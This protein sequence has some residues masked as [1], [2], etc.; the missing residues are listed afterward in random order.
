MN[1]LK[2]CTILLFATLTSIISLANADYNT[3]ISYS[4]ALIRNKRGFGG[5]KS[6]YDPHGMSGMISTLAAA[7]YLVLQ[8]IKEDKFCVINFKVLKIE[9]AL[10]IDPKDHSKFLYPDDKGNIYFK[11]G[12]PVFLSCAQEES[13]CFNRLPKQSSQTFICRLFDFNELACNSHPKHSLKLVKDDSHYQKFEELKYWKDRRLAEY[14]KYTVSK[15]LLAGQ[16]TNVKIPLPPG[17]CCRVIPSILQALNEDAQI[18]SFKELLPYQSYESEKGYFRI[19]GRDRLASR[20]ANVY[21]AAAL[22]TY[23]FTNIIP[24]FKCII[25]NNWPKIDEHINEMAITL[26]KGSDGV[27][28]RS[29]RKGVVYVTVNDIFMDDRSAASYHICKNPIFKM[30]GVKMPRGWQPKKYYAGYSYMCT[31][32]PRGDDEQTEIESFTPAEEKTTPA[33]KRTTTVSHTT[34]EEITTTTEKYWVI[35]DE[36]R[37]RNDYNSRF[38]KKSL[39]IGNLRMIEYPLDSVE[40][41]AEA[42]VGENRIEDVRAVGLVAVPLAVVQHLRAILRDLQATIHRTTVYPLTTFFA[43]DFLA[44]FMLQTVTAGKGKSCSDTDSELRDIMI[45]ESMNLA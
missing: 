27:V 1:T 36:L 41:T 25:S 35:R 30:S 5:T 43:Y 15:S 4:N 26:K 29:E 40:I 23:H 8:Q 6:V 21:S 13:N 9:H 24:L 22:A 31:Y 44:L 38:Y 32:I 14:A 33:K 11:E 3:S 2:M 19:F 45:G 7:M 16:S 10:I 42:L 20:D 12:D 34:T 17:V 37:L 28:D 18:E 39:A